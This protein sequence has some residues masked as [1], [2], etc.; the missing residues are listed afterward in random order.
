M[1]GLLIVKIYLSFF[2]KNDKVFTFNI[3]NF[4]KFETNASL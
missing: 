2:R 1:F 3:V 4:P